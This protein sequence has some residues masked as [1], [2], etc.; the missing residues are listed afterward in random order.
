MDIIPAI[1]PTN[2]T[3]LE[4]KV[5]LVK[6]FVDTV[7]IDICDGQFTQTPTWP[8]KK[9]DDHFAAILEEKEGLPGWDSLD[10]EI[11]LIVNNPEEVIAEWITA[12][13]KRIIIHPKATEKLEECMNLMQG[14]VEIGFAFGID[15][16]VEIMDGV[17]FIQLMGIS[18]IGVQG[19]PL[20]DYVIDKL[21][22]VREQYPDV[23]ISVDGGVNL[24]TALDLGRADRLV[25]GSAIF[26]SHNI[27]QTIEE[28]RSIIN[29]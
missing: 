27:P 22:E 9:S 29:R 11:H 6:G 5:N 25:I 19:E 7:Q 8:Y 17:D 10:F 24:D 18:Q 14:V 2:Y 16:P 1:L 23:P 26:E 15:E 20:N 3:D 21:E 4:D 13:A 12:G 28:F